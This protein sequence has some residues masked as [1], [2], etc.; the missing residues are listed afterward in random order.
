MARP[1]LQHREHHDQLR[2]GARPPT[3]TAGRCTP[4]PAVLPTTV[5]SPST[6]AEPADHEPRA[7]GPGTTMMTKAVTASAIIRPE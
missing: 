6:P 7:L 5:A 3:V 2:P 4:S 1:Q